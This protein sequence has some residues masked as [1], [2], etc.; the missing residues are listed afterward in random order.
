MPRTSKIQ[1]TGHGILDIAYGK[2]SSEFTREVLSPLMVNRSPETSN[3]AA[4]VVNPSAETA[5]LARDVPSPA[6]ET[7]PS[8]VGKKRV[9]KC[10]DPIR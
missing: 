3:A 9:K 8:R 6:R 2:E 10:K 5:N 7:T 1:R 4:A